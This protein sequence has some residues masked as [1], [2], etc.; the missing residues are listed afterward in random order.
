MNKHEIQVRQKT[1]IVLA[2]SSKLMGLTNKI[3]A[4]RKS[5]AVAIKQVIWEKHPEMFEAMMFMEKHNVLEQY[6]SMQ[7][8]DWLIELLHKCGNIN[9]VI[10]DDIYHYFPLCRSTFS[11]NKMVVENRD[12]LWEHWDKLSPYFAVSK[13][14]KVD[15]EM[16]YRLLEDDEKVFESHYIDRMEFDWDLETLLK[17]KDRFNYGSYG[18]VYSAFEWSV[19]FYE[20]VKHK[21]VD[22]IQSLSM[23]G[24][25]SYE[26]MEYLKHDLDWENVSSNEEI[27]WT[28]QMINAFGHLIDADDINRVRYYHMY[29]RKRDYIPKSIYKGTHYAHKFKEIPFPWELVNWEAVAQTPERWFWRALSINCTFKW[30]PKIESL[31]DIYGDWNLLSSNPQVP[32]NEPNFMRKFSHKLN[33]N[34]LSKSESFKWTKE[35]LLAHLDK[36]ESSSSRGDS[37]YLCCYELTENKAITSDKELFDIA[38]S[39]YEEK[40]SAANDIAWGI[41]TSGGYEGLAKWLSSDSNMIDRRKYAAKMFA[42]MYPMTDFTL[43]DALKTFQEIIR[44]NY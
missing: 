36:K 43:E 32:W 33:R 40:D 30:S 7:Q 5:V 24:N 15:K 18:S 29:R 39:M 12:L 22:M 20:A 16:F 3:L 35:Y 27:E 38:Y 26:L 2:K 6:V 37:K 14:A 1:D 11:K 44:R 9:E 21:D 34:E 42:E 23:V 25:L 13:G 8:N 31:F 19:E 17:Y 10:K 4:N 28:P 41:F